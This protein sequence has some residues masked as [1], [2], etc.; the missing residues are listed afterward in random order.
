MRNYIF[1]LIVIFI[2]IGCKQNYDFEKD[3]E[4]AIELLKLELKL[5]NEESVEEVNYWK[6]NNDIVTRFRIKKH[7]ADR[8]KKNLNMHLNLSIEYIYIPEDS[9]TWF[10]P[11][12]FDNTNNIYSSEL[13]NRKKFLQYDEL[14]DV[15][16][17]TNLKWSTK[18]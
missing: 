3:S 16:Y 5:N 1:I 18:N 11:P 17:Y 10:A 13:K 12:M 6:Y 9:P 7:T 2:S 4:E 8:I 14:N 15:Y